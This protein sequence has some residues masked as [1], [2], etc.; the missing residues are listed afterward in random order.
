M[1]KLKTDPVVGI[2]SSTIEWRKK[3]FGTNEFKY[4]DKDVSNLPFESV[5]ELIQ[6]IPLI[7]S[8]NKLGL[9]GKF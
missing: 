1:K 3:A 9:I 7:A 4:L 6:I 2:S 5:D 8:E